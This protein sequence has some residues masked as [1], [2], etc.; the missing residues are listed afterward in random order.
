MNN[1]DEFLML[2]DDDS[3]VIS[4][5]VLKKEDASDTLKSIFRDKT[6][7]DI[8]KLKCLGSY[9]S[10]IDA[11]NYF[12]VI[13]CDKAHITEKPDIIWIKKEKFEAIVKSKNDNMLIKLLDVF[14][15]EEK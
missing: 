2:K 11:L 3:V 6:G 14:Y 12:Y 5:P 15:F 13:M 9:I 1:D 4:V 8:D 10:D 7:N